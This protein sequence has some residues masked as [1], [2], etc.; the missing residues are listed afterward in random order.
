MLKKILLLATVSFFT[1]SSLNAQDVSIDDGIITLDGKKVLK[2]E[3]TGETTASIS[4]LD[5]KELILYTYEMNSTRGYVDDDY[6]R[7]HFLSAKKKVECDQLTHVAPVS[8]KK[9]IRKIVEW[10]L[11][12]KVL[13]NVGEIDSERV[14]VF[15]EKYNKDITARTLR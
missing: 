6:Y 14:E 3:K 9:S 15:Y 1:L 8:I 4:T 7:I 2:Y 5:D 12:E 10:L 11:K 13:N